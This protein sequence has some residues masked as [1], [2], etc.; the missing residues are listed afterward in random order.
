MTACTNPNQPF[1]LHIG[2]A[3]DVLP[4]LP[5]RSVDCIVTSPPY[6]GQRSNEYGGIPEDEYPT[7][8][9]D[10]LDA[11]REALTETGSV[12][13]VIR[14]HI[15]HGQ[16]SDYV[17]RTR[18]ELRSRGWI[19]HDEWIWDKVSGPPTGPNGWPRR[20]WEHILWVSPRRR[21]WCDPLGNG[22]DSE[23]IGITHGR[24]YVKGYGGHE[25][26]GVVRSGRAR[27][28]DLARFS[29]GHNTKGDHVDHPAP[30]PPKLAAWIIRYLCP[31]GGIVCD[32]YCGSGSTG[33]AAI[34]EGRRFVGIDIHSEYI[35]MTR[36]RLSS[37]Q[38]QLPAQA[39]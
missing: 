9:A 6:A 34:G 2:D 19:E 11:A 27:G 29:T 28:I 1:Q 14:P 5:P 31:P 4:K 22:Q 16:L 18:L 15:R 12:A 20:S 7:W 30:Y 25:A 3:L 33:A 24:M 35:N 37:M 13:F 32:P 38:P 17:L 21:P 39:G 36:R 8:F 26:R 10:R 23:R